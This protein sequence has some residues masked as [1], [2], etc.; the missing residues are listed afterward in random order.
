MAT[1]RI[2]IS[3]TYPGAGGPGLNIWH[4]RTTGDAPSGAGELQGLIDVIKGFY[5]AVQTFLADDMT[6]SYLGVATTVD[7]DPVF[8]SGA[9][10]WSLVVNN[11]QG[12]APPV[13][14]VCVNWLTTSASR[15]GRG[16]TFVGPLN[17][18]AI[19]SD[20]TVAPTAISAIRAAASAV[21][22]ASDGFADGAVG[23]YSST[24]NLIRD[25]VGT[26]TRDQF[27]ILTSRRD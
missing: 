3:L 16:R 10:A 18:S 2:P 11:S 12:I 27:A 6:I 5:T 4:V 14:A 21:V 9:E 22:A 17:L 13:L 23:V 25:V 8:D 7:E 19:Q 26:A 20:G 15:S 1:Y 24:Q